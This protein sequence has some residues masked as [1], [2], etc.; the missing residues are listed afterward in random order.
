MKYDLIGYNIDNL[1]RTLYTKKITLLNVERPSQTHVKF[2]LKDKHDKKAK[3]YED[4][5]MIEATCQLKASLLK[6][7]F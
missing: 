2:E 1:L 4:V 5:A 3:K 7:T 6:G